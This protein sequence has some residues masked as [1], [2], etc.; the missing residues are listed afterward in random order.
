MEVR[1]TLPPAGHEC[2]AIAAAARRPPHQARVPRRPARMPRRQAP[3]QRVPRAGLA[4]RRSATYTRATGP[5]TRSAVAQWPRGRRTNNQALPCQP[6]KK[7]APR[8]RST[9]ALIP[10]TPGPAV[11]CR[12]LPASGPSGGGQAPSGNPRDENCRARQRRIRVT[13]PSDIS[14]SWRIGPG[15]RS[16]PCAFPFP[17]RIE[18]AGEHTRVSIVAAGS[19]WPAGTAVPGTGWTQAARKASPCPGPVT[20]DVPSPPASSARTA[21]PTR[22][23]HAWC[24]P[25][26]RASAAATAAVVGQPVLSPPPVPCGTAPSYV[27]AKTALPMRRG[28][29]TTGVAVDD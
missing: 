28:C 11:K 24:R 29:A 7:I 5:A 17:V 10:D 8:R 27:S 13:T 26:S 6:T 12:M 15:P 18:P 16:A 9:P 4:E 21:C 1:R 14:C 20:P 22:I 19:G 23:A 3:V 2:R 25:P